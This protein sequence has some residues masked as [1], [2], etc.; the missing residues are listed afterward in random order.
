MSQ[1][2]SD[3]LTREQRYWRWK[4]LTAT[5]VGY[6]GYYLVRKV[7]T[8]C[9]TSIARDFNW[10]LS[11]VA[12][13]WTAFLVGYMI[14][15]FA[16]SF[17]GRKF[18]P[19][20]I[21]LVGLGISIAC[22]VIFGITNSYMTF[23]VFMFINGLVQATGWPG[24]VGGVSAW[25]RPHE[26]GTI[27]GIW[28]SNHFAGNMFVKAVGAMLLGYL[29][30]RTAFF[31]CTAMTFFVWWLLYFWHRDKPEDVGLPP[32]LKKDAEDTRAVKGSDADHISFGEYLRI[33]MNPLVL[34][35]GSSY[36]CIKFLRYA[37]DSWLPAFLN[38]Q[39][40]DVASAGIHSMWFD[41]GGVLG[42]IVSGIILDRYLKGRWALVC[43]VMGIGM[44]ISYY[45][46]AYL[47]TSPL[48]ISLIFGIVGFMVCGPDSIL[49]GMAVVDVVGAKNAVAAA[50][51]I[52]G[53]GSIG[54]IIQEEVIGRL[55]R[56][57]VQQGI[58]NTHVL[59]LGISVV[60]MVLMVITM[61][62]IASTTRRKTS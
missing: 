36:L 61:M 3:E 19:K 32:I 14:G 30:W 45:C 4:I 37:L 31:G 13:I 33:I 57:D 34:I 1:S 40:M 56:G 41:I 60:F 62:W 7:F 27:L 49:C 38:I 47:G 54:P 20:S 28:S 50:G 2:V 10:E 29:G 46:V 39:G 53:I 35:M 15:Q 17:L 58:Q 42:S 16:S 43:L 18:G 48:M 25:I 6:A 22:N 44:V 59:T 11:D 21:M 26:R 51:L 24:S 8:I 5:F 12:H 52:N 23:M 55:M 9:K